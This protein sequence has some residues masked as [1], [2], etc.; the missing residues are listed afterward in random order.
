ML[1]Y[2]L[3]STMNHRMN[4]FTKILNEGL[5][6][7]QKGASGGSVIGVDIGTSSIKIVE[8]KKKGGKAVLETYGS[9]ALGPYA[10]LDV[11]AVTNLATE[12]LSQAL[13]DVVRES[14]ATVSSGG[15]SIPS[16]ASLIFV[17]ELPPVISDKE[18]A[19]VIPTEARKYI[20]VPI[21]EV[22]LDYWVIPKKEEHYAEGAAPKEKTEVLLAAIHNDTISKYKSVVSTAKLHPNFFEIETFSAIR[23]T[24]SHELSPVLLLDFGASRTKLAIVEYGIIKSFHVINRGSQDITNALSKSL[25]VPFSKAEEMKR[26]FGLSGS[27]L[28]RN[29]AD[30]TRLTVDFILSEANAAIL[31]YE[32]KYGKSV[33]KIILSGGGS[34]LKGFTEAAH[35]NF[36]AEVAL[37]DPFAKVTAPAFLEGVLASIGPEFSV[38][39]GLALRELQ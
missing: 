23:S 31:A 18:L 35:T 20:P 1:L 10:T 36:A 9:L 3:D 14:G 15:F 33:S 34:L 38:A 6:F 13:V 24:F 27:S 4:P 22:M 39:I 17:I 25:S 7:F 19:S 32:R 29:V 37:G 28:D 26:E 5:A 21:A 8:L 11:G 30:I 2:M 16:T 12:K